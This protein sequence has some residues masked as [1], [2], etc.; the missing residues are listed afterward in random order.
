MVN[1]QRQKLIIRDDKVV[2]VY[3]L[4]FVVIQMTRANREKG[5]Y[6]DSN[7][8]NSDESVYNHVLFMSFS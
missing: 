4:D 1:E 8:S 2:L 3:M 5:Y 6:S 7:T